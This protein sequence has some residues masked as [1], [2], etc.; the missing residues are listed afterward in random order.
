MDPKYWT[1]E[2]VK[3]WIQVIENK[4]YQK[5]VNNFKYVNGLLLRYITS[6]ELGQRI[7]NET[8]RVDFENHLR[9]LFPVE[10]RQ[11]LFPFHSREDMIDSLIIPVVEIN[12]GYDI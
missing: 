9:L 12:C 11:I 4:R 1:S 5:Y 8:D 3:S 6:M 2:E 10:N 7:S